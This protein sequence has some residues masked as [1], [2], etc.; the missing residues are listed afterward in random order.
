MIGVIASVVLSSAF[1]LSSD[2]SNE[3]VSDVNRDGIVQV[4]AKTPRGTSFGSAFA[5]NHNGKVLLGSAAHVC[6]S[7]YRDPFNGK[8]YMDARLGHRIRRAQ[9]VALNYQ[10]DLC[11][12]KTS[13][14]FKK[15]FN[16]AKDIPDYNDK[17]YS[18]GYT[19]QF[20]NLNVESGPMNNFFKF[21]NYA[22]VANKEQ[23]EKIYNSQAKLV[24][25]QVFIWTVKYCPYRT[26]INV[27]SMS[28]IGGMSGGP[29]IDN[30][31][32]V[33]GVNRFTFTR[34]HKLATSSSRDL[35]RLANKYDKNPRKSIK[36][37]KDTYELLRPK[38]VKVQELGVK[39]KNS[40]YQRMYKYKMGKLR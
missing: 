36:N 2:A 6:N 31:G 29:M 12:L 18:L 37:V 28:G 13:F 35:I 16:L 7:A 14:K 32:K 24:K 20:K 26:K 4:S 1:F 17:L 25:R 9:I 5:F 38:T 40:M 10:H 34:V 15:V 21:V 3:R 19:P 23:C 27:T 22:Q 8:Y 39:N 33:I 30:S 11:I